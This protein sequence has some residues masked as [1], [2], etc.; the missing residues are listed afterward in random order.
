MILDHDLLVNAKSMD[1]FHGLKRT[2]RIVDIG[3][4]IRPCRAFKAEHIC[5]EPHHEYIAELRTC[6]EVSEI[7]EGEA[8]LVDRFPRQGTT[9]FLLD[10]I[11]HME[12]E[13]GEKI[14]DL[15]MDFEQAVIFTPLG[16]ME[17]SDKNPD[18]W[19]YNGGFWQKHRSGWQV[20]DFP[21]WEVTSWPVWHARSMTGAILAIHDLHRDAV[22]AA[23]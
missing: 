7:V 23:A 22:L 6:R 15:L 11:E 18:A 5:I 2:D 3:A 4:G 13:R 9:V 10:V 8:E 17:Q 19:G 14:R 1:I 20:E 16:F 21:G 12:R